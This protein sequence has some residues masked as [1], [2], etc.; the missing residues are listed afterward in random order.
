MDVVVLDVLVVVVVV[1]VHSLPS[2]GREYGDHNPPNKM[3][4]VDRGR[5]C[6]SN[7]LFESSLTLFEPHVV[8]ANSLLEISGSFPR[9]IRPARTLAS[10]RPVI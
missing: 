4:E 1:V 6:L 2:Y 3:D 5:T 9:H 10:L 7:N 8:R